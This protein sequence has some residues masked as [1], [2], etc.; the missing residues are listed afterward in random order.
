MVMPGCAHRLAIRW[1]A[2]LRVGDRHGAPYDTLLQAD[3]C[4]WVPAAIGRDPQPFM[5]LRD[6]LAKPTVL[7]LYPS[8]KTICR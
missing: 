4:A 2:S 5:D 6:Q 1:I 8:I 7:R 3:I